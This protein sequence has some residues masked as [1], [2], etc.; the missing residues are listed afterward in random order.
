MPD[1]KPF[2]LH[3]G[4]L[5]VGGIQLLDLSPIDLFAMLTTDYLKACNLPPAITSHGIPSS[6]LKITYIASTGAGSLAPTTPNLKFHI[7]AGLDDESV[8]PGKLDILMI[9]GPDPNKVPEEPALEFLRKH[10]EKGVEVLTICTGIF[11]AGHA[12]ILDGKNAT[13]GR[14]IVDMMLKKQ[15][16]KAKWR[17]DVRWTTDEKLWTAGGITNGQDMVA[18]YIRKRWPGTLSETV[19]KLA[20]VGDRGQ[21]YP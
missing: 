1:P 7:D 16:P 2:P 18:A 13:G 15:F 21:Y 3:I 20:D 9:P 4:V 5:V 17:D 8:K 12:G 19:C 6:E 11:V 14:E 10:V